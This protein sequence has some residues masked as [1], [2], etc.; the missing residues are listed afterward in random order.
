MFEFVYLDFQIHTCIHLVN[1]SNKILQLFLR[2]VIECHFFTFSFSQTP[3]MDQLNCF[4]EIWIECYIKTMFK[5][6]YLNFQ[7]H[8]SMHPV[9]CSKKILRLFPTFSFSQIS[10]IH[11]LNWFIKV[12]FSY[13]LT[14]FIYTQRPTK[15]VICFSIK[16][17]INQIK[18]C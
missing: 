1:C 13:I 15:K 7:E 2:K 3:W 8:S 9:N 18:T 4:K 17:K 14:Q 5:F 11:H 6:V 16:I 10:Y 12:N